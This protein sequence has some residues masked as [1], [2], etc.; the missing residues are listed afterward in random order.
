MIEVT[1]PLEETASSIP[2][3][4]T[5]RSIT[6]GDRRKYRS[7]STGAPTCSRRS[8]SCREGSPTSAPR[9]RPRDDSDGADVGGGL[10]ILG[11]SLTSDSVSLVD[12][13]D[14]A[15][16]QIR[17]ALMRVGGVARV[18]VT[19]GDTR[20]FR[21]T[22]A[23]EKLAAYHLDIRQVADAIQKAN[24]VS[25]AGLVENN[26]RLYLSLVSASTGA[27]RTSAPALWPFAVESP[28]GSATWR[29]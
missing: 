16:Y 23:P 12:L 7:T 29:R 4:S 18:E 20:E 17:P 6:A 19:G 13:R 3:V 26:F 2:G 24:L 10:P 9:F 22:V 28:C 8:S 14:I 1:K 11:Y 21:V 15:L 25:S 5:V 27:P